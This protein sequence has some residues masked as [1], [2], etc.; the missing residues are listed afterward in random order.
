MSLVKGVSI[1]YF[2]FSNENLYIG[3][4]SGYSVKRMAAH[5]SPD[6]SFLKNYTRVNIESFGDECLRFISFD[7]GIVSNKKL[8]QAVEHSLHLKLSANPFLNNLPYNIISSTKKTAPRNYDYFEADEIATN[9]L[10]SLRKVLS[11]NT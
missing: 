5:L 9:T 7:I 10:I 3:E 11:N 2:I 6:G 4:T 8:L 1:I